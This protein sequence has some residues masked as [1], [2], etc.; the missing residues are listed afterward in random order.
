MTKKQHI[1]NLDYLFDIYTNSEDDFDD[2]LNIFFEQATEWLIIIPEYHKNRDWLA[3]CAT[4][5]QAKSSVRI[6]GMDDIASNIIKLENLSKIELKQYL[7]KKKAKAIP[8][9]KKECYYW[10]NIKETKDISDYTIRLEKI[11]N[12]FSVDLPEAITELKSIKNKLKPLNDE[13][14]L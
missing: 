1:T 12:Q 13:H 3:L 8:F 11:I 7:Q 10:K 14:Q 9:S 6:M 5:H 2:L 4:L